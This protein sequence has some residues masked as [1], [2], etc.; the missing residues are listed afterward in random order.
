MKLYLSEVQL[1]HAIFS[2]RSHALEYSEFDRFR[3]EASPPLSGMFIL[4]KTYTICTVDM[5]LR[6]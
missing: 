4:V 2:T 6:S 5:A 3:C 1:S